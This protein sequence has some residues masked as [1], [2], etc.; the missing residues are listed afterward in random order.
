MRGALHSVRDVIDHDGLRPK[1]PNAEPE[2]EPLDLP[3]FH[4]N[5]RVCTKSSNLVP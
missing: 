3:H 5:M 4:S 2:R 1:N